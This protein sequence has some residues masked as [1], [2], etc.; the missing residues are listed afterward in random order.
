M[1]LL[2]EKVLGICIYIL[3]PDLKAIRQ[4]LHGLSQISIGTLSPVSN[5]L[6]VPNKSLTSYVER[7]RSL[8]GTIRDE[9]L[10]H[11]SHLSMSFHQVYLWEHRSRPQCRRVAAHLVGE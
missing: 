1:R 3:S 5:V 8:P 11:C 7:V 6:R 10:L 2:L 9:L 4:P